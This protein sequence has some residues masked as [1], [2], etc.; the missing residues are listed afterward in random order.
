[1]K[2][3]DINALCIAKKKLKK[4]MRPTVIE[5]VFSPWKSEILPLNYERYL[6]NTNYYRSKKRYK[7]KYY[8]LIQKPP[9][10]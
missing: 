6:L 9:P 5:T 10:Q 4:K 8:N 1:M 3:K 2:C 7:N